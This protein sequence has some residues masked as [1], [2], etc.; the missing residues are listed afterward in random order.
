M[1]ERWRWT[2]KHLECM[3]NSVCSLSRN[4]VCRKEKK[5][6][7]GEMA[8]DKLSRRFFITRVCL[9]SV[10]KLFAMCL[11]ENILYLL[12][13]SIPHSTH[14]IWMRSTQKEKDA[15]ERLVR[16][17]VQKA[18]ETGSRDVHVAVRRPL[19]IPWIRLREWVSIYK[20]QRYHIPELFI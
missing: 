7:L 16:H 6:C 5:C 18:Q 15:D 12:I 19:G 17:R 1:E 13:K 2:A 8:S 20:S 4:A 14:N 10:F 11:Y 3:Y 9:H